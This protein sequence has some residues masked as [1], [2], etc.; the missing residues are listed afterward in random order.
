MRTQIF[1]IAALVGL[2]F[3][4]SAENYIVDHAYE[5]AVSEIRLPGSV[6]GT[7][8]IKKCASCDVQTIRVTSDTR[9]VLNNRDVPL[10]D[11]RRAVSSILDKRKN[12]A[13]VIHRL[14]SDTV[15]AV[16]VVE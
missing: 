10:E 13:T 11:F 9:Y 6:A 14:E 3:A 8:A 2:S 7:I 12:I 5:I 15:V 16:R 4:A 1:L